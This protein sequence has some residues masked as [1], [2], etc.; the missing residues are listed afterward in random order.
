MANEAAAAAVVSR[1]FSRDSP[2][3]LGA[4]AAVETGNRRAPEDRSRG[5]ATAQGAQASAIVYQDSFFFLR[6]ESRKQKVLSRGRAAFSRLFSL[7]I[8]TPTSTSAP[9]PS[10]SLSFR[11]CVWLF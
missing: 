5:R 6:V 8:S 1:R 2:P 4:A 11:V 3:A 9:S 10:L 7:I